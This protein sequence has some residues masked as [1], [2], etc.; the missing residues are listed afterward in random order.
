MVVVEW[1]VG[2]SDGVVWVGGWVGG[3]GRGGGGSD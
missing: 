2:G 3:W 1:W